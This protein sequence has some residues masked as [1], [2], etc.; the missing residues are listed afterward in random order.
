[1]LDMKGGVYTA[2]LCAPG[3]SS[4]YGTNHDLDH[5]LDPLF[6]VMRGFSGSVS[7]RSGPR[8]I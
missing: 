1:M 2:P 4:A 8:N 3:K 7:Y 5:N 6:A